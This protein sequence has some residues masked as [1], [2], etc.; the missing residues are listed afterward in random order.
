MTCQ[1][2]A[3]PTLTSKFRDELSSRKEK[4]EK[5]NITHFIPCGSKGKSYHVGVIVQQ[6]LGRLKNMTP[7]DLENL[8]VSSP[9]GQEFNADETGSDSEEVTEQTVRRA[10]T[11]IHQHIALA[12]KHTS[13]K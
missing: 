3:Q 9:S 7:K 1:R 12:T 2:Y 6:E 5:E 13:K 10:L 8:L 11:N 4:E